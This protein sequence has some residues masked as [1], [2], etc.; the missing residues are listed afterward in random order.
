GG[1]G[2]VRPRGERRLMADTDPNT[3]LAAS[4]AKLKEALD[5]ERAEHKA[6]KAQLLA[7]VRAALGLPDDAPLDSIIA[8][9]AD[10]DAQ[11]TERTA[12][13]TAERDAARSEADRIKAE[14]NTERIDA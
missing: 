10:V 7:P 13:L 3:D 14:R 2:A 5:K 9:I 4:V 1:A 11:L 12:A 6:T 8:R